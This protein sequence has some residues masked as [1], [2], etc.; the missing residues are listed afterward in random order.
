[1]T[2]RPTQSGPAPEL[3]AAAY[4]TLESFFSGYLHEDFVSEHG[5][6]EG[7]LRMW[8]MDANAKEKSR[9][10][11]EAAAFLSVAS[12]LPFETVAGFVR[13]ELGSAW[14]PS[15]LKRLEDLFT[16]SPRRT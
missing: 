1:M 4:P 2:S 13:R 3:R 8:R 7:A 10:G 15:S 6:P 14:R 5:T 12:Q 11:A 9:L 16:P